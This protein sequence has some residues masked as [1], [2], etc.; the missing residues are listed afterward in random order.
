ME[1]VANAIAFLGLTCGGEESST[2][3]SAAK[4]GILLVIAARTRGGG[5]VDTGIGELMICGV[6]TGN[7]DLVSGRGFL[8]LVEVLVVGTIIL[9]EG[10]IVE[11]MLV[12]VDLGVDIGVSVGRG[13]GSL[14]NLFGAEVAGDGEGF[15]NTVGFLGTGGFWLVLGITALAVD[16]R[17]AS[18]GFKVTQGC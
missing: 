5:G 14:D 4:G 10:V 8:S 18:C 17:E 12:D 9:F 3:C 13:G 16:G 1:P 7:G 2:T 15:A 6:G 11:S